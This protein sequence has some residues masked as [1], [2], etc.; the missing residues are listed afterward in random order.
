[1]STMAYQITSVLIVYSTVCSGSDQ[2]KHQSSASLAFV[3]EFTGDRW[4]PLIDGQSR[5]KYFHLMTS[6]WQIS[7]LWSV[8][9][10]AQ[11]LMPFNWY[12]FWQWVMVKSLTLVSLLLPLLS[13]SLVLLTLLFKHWKVPLGFRRTQLMALS[14]WW[15]YIYIYICIRYGF[16]I[17]NLCSKKELNTCIGRVWLVRVRWSYSHN[18][19]ALPTGRTRISWR[20]LHW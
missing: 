9:Y 6:S 16:V 14:K 1:M 10:S 18:S 19:R 3:R 20:Y 8:H 15:I 12:Q 13:L 5:G 7:P 11:C 2:G 17:Y 4:F